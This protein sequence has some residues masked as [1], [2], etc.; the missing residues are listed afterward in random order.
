M[1]VISLCFLLKKP[2]LDPFIFHKM[3]SAY[4]PTATE[5]KTRQ[6]SFWGAYIS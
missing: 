4:I 1:D 5:W 6:I 3:W 2:C